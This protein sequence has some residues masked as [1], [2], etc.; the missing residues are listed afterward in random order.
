MIYKQ[1]G[2][3]AGEEVWVLKI[4]G[5]HLSS[6]SRQRDPKS[7]TPQAMF[8]GGILMEQGGNIPDKILA[9]FFS[10]LEKSKAG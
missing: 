1:R 3:W 5:Y 8:P 7:I 4:T 2:V 9:F 10:C 6:I